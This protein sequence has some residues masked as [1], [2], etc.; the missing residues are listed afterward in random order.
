MMIFDILCLLMWQAITSDGI[1]GISMHQ[2]TKC[3]YWVTQRGVYNLGSHVFLTKR[4]Q[5]CIS[6]A[7]WEEKNFGFQKILREGKYISQLMEDEL[8]S[9]DCFVASSGLTRVILCFLVEK[10]GRYLHKF[11]FC[12]QLNRRAENNL[13]FLLFS[14][15]LLPEN[16]CY[17]KR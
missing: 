17:I 15:L 8:V 2:L 1:K 14:Q 11:I 13:L 5:V 3:Y 6:V 16:N 12:F 7:R 10:E 9:V 4:N